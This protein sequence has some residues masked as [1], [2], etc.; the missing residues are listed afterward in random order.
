MLGRRIVFVEAWLELHNKILAPQAAYEQD[1]F[2][3]ALDAGSD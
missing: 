2:G 3:L 1:W